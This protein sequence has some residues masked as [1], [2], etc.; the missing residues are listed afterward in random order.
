MLVRNCGCAFS[1]VS[2][3]LPHFP[4]FAALLASP[5]RADGAA[6]CL[7]GEFSRL[8]ILPM[9]FFD[10]SDSFRLKPLPSNNMLPP[11]FCSHLLT[12]PD[13]SIDRERR[14]SPLKDVAAEAAAWRGMKEPHIAGA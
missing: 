14:A 3:W 1:R 12:S 9:S 7:C 4:G 5:L 6:S 10:A 13:V 2:F 8:P 11:L